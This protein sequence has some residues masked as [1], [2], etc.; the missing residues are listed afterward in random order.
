MPKIKAVFL[1]RDGVINRYP[2]Y[3]KYVTA[4]KDFKFLSGAKEAI[5]RLHAAGF[6]LFV[7]SNQAGVGNGIYSRK[8]LALINRNMLRQ[9]KKAK[10][11]LD[12]IYCCTHRPEEHCSCRK[13]KAG[14]IN[15][16]RKKYPIDIRRSFF[17]GD[18]VR[19]VKTAHAAGCK[20]IMVLSGKEKLANR[21]NWEAAPDYIFRNLL[22]AADFILKI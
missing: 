10:G 15:L 12:G 6:K 5:A 22:E 1:D 9:I 13:P 17:I 11:H 2:G 4:W 14:A 7:I 20:S 19:D 3:P 8:K 21:R 18:T 16:I